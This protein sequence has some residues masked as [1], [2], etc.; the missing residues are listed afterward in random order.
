MLN[1]RLHY[2]I[3]TQFHCEMKRCFYILD[4]RQTISTR[5]DHLCVGRVDIGFVVSLEMEASIFFGFSGKTS[6]TSVLSTNRDHFHVH[7]HLRRL[8]PLKYDTNNNINRK[9]TVVINH[10]WISYDYWRYFEQKENSHRT[11]TRCLTYG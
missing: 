8:G 10:C 5:A 9:I 6:R 2:S 7:F 4:V 11:D 1:V 3:F